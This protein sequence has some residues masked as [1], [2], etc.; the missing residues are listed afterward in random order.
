MNIK[1]TISL[2]ISCVLLLL[3]A[4]ITGCTPKQEAPVYDNYAGLVPDCAD[5]YVLKHEG[6]YYLYGTGGQKGIRVYV[7]DNLANWSEAAG[8]RDGFALDS[9]DVWGNRGFWAPEVYRINN[10]FYMYF[11]V[12]ERIAVAESDSPLGPFV[13]PV[14][15]PFHLDIPEIDTHLFID[16][17]GT[18]YL[19]FVRFTNGNEI[20]AAMLNDDLRSIDDETLT[21]CFGQSQAWE[22]SSREPYPHAKVNEGPFI[23]KHNGIYYLTYSANHTANPDYGVG[24]ATAKH[25]LGPWEKYA[26][27]PILTGDGEKINGPGHHSFTT[28]PSGQPYIVYHTHFDMTK[29]GPRKTAIDPCEFVKDENGGA[30]IL[31]IYGPTSSPQK[32]K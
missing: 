7:S 5:P 8:A 4:G 26:G 17:D 16:D 9:T 3:A 19:Y 24:Y 23:L 21:Y 12:Q 25:P 27:N 14:M 10:K 28:S 11:T 31:K 29:M 6:K 13:Q 15:E 32:V 2:G 20:W 22:D 30:D 1:K 18:K